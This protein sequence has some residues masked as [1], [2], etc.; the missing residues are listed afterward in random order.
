MSPHWDE[1]KPRKISAGA[2]YVA[3]RNPPMI[4]TSYLLA[5]PCPI[6]LTVANRATFTPLNRL[7]VQIV[8]RDLHVL[9]KSLSRGIVRAGQVFP[10]TA[11]ES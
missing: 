9:A 3:L 4:G 7:G 11:A 6:Q 5:L 10:K 2:A 1:N 8:G